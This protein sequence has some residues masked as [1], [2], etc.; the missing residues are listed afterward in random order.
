MTMS[1]SEPA[2]PLPQ[3]RDKGGHGIG[4]PAG[5][6]NVRLPK[7]EGR[8]DKPASLPPSTAEEDPH[9]DFA[10]ST[11]YKIRS[12]A[13]TVPTEE[14]K[15]RTKTSFESLRGYFKDRDAVLKEHA[16]LLEAQYSKTDFHKQLSKL[17][18]T[19]K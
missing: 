3:D 15:A 2:L 7:L 14:S 10:R 8:R 13:R 19:R 16:P 12:Q 17:G 1:M 4:K 6:V 11:F 9:S 5:E 18:W